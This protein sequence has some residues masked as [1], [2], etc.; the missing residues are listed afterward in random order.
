MGKLDCYH[1]P[2]DSVKEPWD[3]DELDNIRAGAKRWSCTYKKNNQN[4]WNYLPT[5]VEKELVLWFF[6]PLKQKGSSNQ[7]QGIESN[8]PKQRKADIFC[9][10]DRN[11]MNKDAF[12]TKK[13]LVFHHALV[14]DLTSMELTFFIAVVF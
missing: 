7:E 11:K 8:L 9:E 6:L 12:K 5:A 3:A 14:L 2:L 10:E 13:N 4:M 1:E